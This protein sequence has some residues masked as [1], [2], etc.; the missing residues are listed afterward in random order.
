M[1]KTTMIDHRINKPANKSGPQQPLVP[2][3]SHAKGKGG[4]MTNGRGKNTAI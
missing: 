1:N 3:S 2:G 4:K